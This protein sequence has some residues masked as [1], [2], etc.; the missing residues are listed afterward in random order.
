MIDG[1]YQ[2][3][4]VGPSDGADQALWPVHM[5]AIR[6]EIIWYKLW[7]REYAFLPYDM[8]N[9]SQIAFDIKKNNFYIITKKR[10]YPM[11]KKTNY[12]KINKLK[13]IQTF[14]NHNK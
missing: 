2:I 9:T 12:L 1:P 3:T 11:K 7:A 4:F 10:L 13:N 8:K 5:V 6:Q 14:Q